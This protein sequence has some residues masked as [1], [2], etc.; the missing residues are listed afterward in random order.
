MS[1]ARVPEAH[2]P[3]TLP[4]TL[5]SAAALLATCITIFTTPVPM[6]LLIGLQICMEDGEDLNMGCSRSRSGSTPLL[7]KKLWRPAL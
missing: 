6:K 3:T 5:D 2:N 4:D 1:L 7:F